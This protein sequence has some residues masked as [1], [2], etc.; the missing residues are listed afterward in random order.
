MGQVGELVCTVIARE[1]ILHEKKKGGTLDFLKGKPGTVVKFNKKISLEFFK[2]YACKMTL[3]DPRGVQWRQQHEY[4]LVLH[5]ERRDGS[6]DSLFFFDVTTSKNWFSDKCD[7]DLFFKKVGSRLRPDFAAQR[8][9]VPIFTEDPS[10]PYDI[11]QKEVSVV[12]L[13]LFPS[14]KALVGR[15]C[16]QLHG[17]IQEI[18]SD[19]GVA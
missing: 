6:P 3:H 16:R 13:P 7:Y 12:H 17:Y 18:C 15:T 14:V 5:E 1:I 10:S 4:D 11:R 19:Q 8:I 9:L 2:G